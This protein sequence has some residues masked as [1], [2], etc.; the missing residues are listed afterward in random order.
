MQIS[1]ISFNNSVCPAKFHKNNPIKNPVTFKGYKFEKP[2]TLIEALNIKI[3]GYVADFSTHSGLINQFKELIKYMPKK[4]KEQRLTEILGSGARSIALERT[5]GEVLKL[6]V[7][8]PFKNG[9]PIEDFD[10]PILEMKR[11]HFGQ[12]EYYYSIQ[13]KCSFNNIKGDDAEVLINKILDKGYDIDFEELRGRSGQFGY[14][15]AGKLCVV[16]SEIVR[17]R[18]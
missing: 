18:F 10:V 7:N 4:L 14:T 11:F 12:H 17:K 9:R 13:E 5:D 15:R 3:D 16:D 6:S 1:P 2:L 8:N